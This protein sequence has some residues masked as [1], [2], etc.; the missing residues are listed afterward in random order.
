[1]FE[2]ILLND[3]SHYAP[4]LAQWAYNQWYRERNISYDII[5]L[6]YRKRATNVNIPLT[7]IAMENDIPEGMCT[8][9][10]NDLW[11][12][13]ELNPWLSSL[14]VIPESR[15]KGIA[16]KLVDKVIVKARDLDFR[17]LYL[18]LGQGSNIDLDG[19]YRKL[20]W[21]YHSDGIDN[22]GLPTKI[23]CYSVL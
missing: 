20:G 3:R 17:K 23:F 21:N 8:L 15:N 4:L 22:E 12:R 13:R 6:E 7:W 11:S 10:E 2:I 1:M 18:F 14:Y 19:F 16:G 9:K 5:N